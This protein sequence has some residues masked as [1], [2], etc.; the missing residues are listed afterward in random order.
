MLSTDSV[1]LPVK[2]KREREREKKEIIFKGKTE[3]L[4]FPFQKTMNIVQIKREYT[5]VRK[6]L[7]T[8]EKTQSVDRRS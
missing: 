4:R 2:R 5:K 3:R 1:G 8:K 7:A 6:V